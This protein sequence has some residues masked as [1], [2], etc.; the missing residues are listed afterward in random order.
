M[1][2]FHEFTSIT[3]NATPDRVWQALTE[4]RPETRKLLP[5]LGTPPFDASE[6]QTPR[7]LVLKGNGDAAPTVRFRVSA[8]QPSDAYTLLTIET[9]ARIASNL[10]G[11][12]I[13]PFIRR[14]HR[15]LL[16]LAARSAKRANTEPSKQ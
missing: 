16:A 12:L 5:G 9:E 14:T 2:R 1:A 11:M 4:L 13:R 10:Q 8:D 15:K 3:V 6:S 7:E